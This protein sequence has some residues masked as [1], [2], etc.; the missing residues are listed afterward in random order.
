MS[1]ATGTLYL[2]TAS[3]GEAPAATNDNPN[4]RAPITPD[5]FKILVL[6]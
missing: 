1:K 5:S 3:F 4:P 6:K 2:P